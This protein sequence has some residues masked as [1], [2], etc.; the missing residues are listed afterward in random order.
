LRAV[1][2]HELAHIKRGDLWVNLAQTVLQIV[3]FY[4]PLLWFANAMIRRVREQAVDEMVLVA[5]GERAKSYP[6]TLVNVAKLAFKQPTLSL[7]LIGVVE[8]KN[9][10]AGRIKRILTRPLPKS[11]KLGILGLIAV[12]LVGAVLLPMAKVE[13]ADVQ[14]EEKK[15]LPVGDYA[16]EFDGID[17]FLEIHASKSLQ[18]GRHFTIQMWIK[19]EFPDTSTPDKDRNLLSK[20]GHILWAPDE[21]GNR[22]AGS[23]GFGFQLRPKDDSMVALDMSTANG[24]IYTSTNI[25]SYESG[26]KHLAISSRENSGVSRGINYVCNSQKAYKPAPNSNLIIGGKF[27]IPRGN[28]FKGQIAELRIWN[29]A[30]SLDEIAEFKTITLNGSEPNLVGCWN[31]EKTEG[32][33][34]IRLGSSWN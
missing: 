4:N 26:W 11:A 28:P 21:K 12:L 9:A 8:S 10:L 24:A 15:V 34:A 16:L 14:V 31:F 6:E 32:R 22:K 7:R 19:P 18:L 25:F 23:Y 27:L 13:K 17:D 2:L 33:R 3:Y 30:L 5:M 29:R 1:L 20:G